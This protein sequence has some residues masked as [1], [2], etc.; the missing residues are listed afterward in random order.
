MADFDRQRAVAQFVFAAFDSHAA[1]LGARLQ[2]E[3]R[4]NAI[5]CSP[6]ADFFNN[7]IGLVLEAYASQRAADPKSMPNAIWPC[8]D[9]AEFKIEIPRIAE[10]YLRLTEIHV[11]PI[12]NFLCRALLDSEIYPLGREVNDPVSAI[13]SASG[14]RVAA[15]VLDQQSASAVATWMGGIALLVVAALFAI[16]EV[17]WLAVLLLIGAVWLFVARSRRTAKINT[18][19]AEVSQ[20]LRAIYN[21]LVQ[22][23][24]EV[25]GGS[26]NSAAIEARLKAA[27][28]DGAYVPSIIYSLLQPRGR[29]S[30]L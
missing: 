5:I 1:P 2:K 12:T 9:H 28:T 19:L 3:L 29:T 11:P 23:R 26:Y 18:A 27:E 8:I 6:V 24:D 10:T 22:V 17:N 16:A 7:D 4:D 25:S 14:P 13:A 20:R 21:R 30:A 15:A